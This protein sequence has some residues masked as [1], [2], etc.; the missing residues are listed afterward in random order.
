LAVFLIYGNTKHEA[1]KK[2]LVQRR[3]N[4][5]AEEGIRFVTGTDVRARLPAVDQL[6]AEF[7]A[8]VLCGGAPARD[9]S[10]EGR[11]LQGIH[12]AMEFLTATL[13]A[14]SIVITRM[15]GIYRPRIKT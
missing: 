11:N 10:I 3:L 12:F 5:M 8:I 2:T 15:A 6:L 7:D 14:S 4:L 1:R 9:L 13:R